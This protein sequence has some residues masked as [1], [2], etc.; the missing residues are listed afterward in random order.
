MAQEHDMTM[1]DR[2]T[3]AA[4]GRFWLWAVGTAAVL[5]AVEEAAFP[6][7]TDARLWLLVLAWLLVAP[8][9][10][11]AAVA[12]GNRRRQP[13]TL[14]TLGAVM[15]GVVV[16]LLAAVSV[17]DS[18]RSGCLTPGSTPMPYPR[19]SPSI[20]PSKG[21]RAAGTGGGR[22]RLHPPGG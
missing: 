18:F 15:T 22:P 10:A 11:G 4:Q 20:S 16:V 6:L 19:Q 13:A 12:I 9:L 21:Q 17:P 2:V 7:S 8:V 14:W 1:G 3:T 5:V